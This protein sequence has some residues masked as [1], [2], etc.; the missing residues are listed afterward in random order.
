LLALVEL[1]TSP[2]INSAGKSDNRNFRELA[3]QKRLEFLKKKS[4]SK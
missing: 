2:T 1:I 4:D 3:E